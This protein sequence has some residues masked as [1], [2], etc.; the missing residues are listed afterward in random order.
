MKTPAY[1][2]SVTT[3]VALGYAAGFATDGIV[4]ADTQP[5]TLQKVVS[6]DLGAGAASTFEGFLLNQMCPQIDS[7]FGLAA[8]TCDVDDI[9][10]KTQG[11]TVQWDD[12]DNPPDGVKEW[13]MRVHVGWVGTYSPQAP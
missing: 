13:Q 7:A 1:L 10:D 12:F 11:V 6:L 5:H 3:A 8:D 9:K 4:A 2:I